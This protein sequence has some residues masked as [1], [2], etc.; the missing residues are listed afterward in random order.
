MEFGSVA[1]VITDD[2]WRLTRYA[3]DG[4]TQLFDLTNDPDERRDRSADPECTARKVSMLEQLTELL[5]LPHRVPQYR[6]IV[7]LDGFRV[8]PN[9][10]NGGQRGHSYPA[11]DLAATPRFQ[12]LGSP[13]ARKEEPK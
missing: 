7:E 10:N 9:P 5:L 6:A 11:Y 13:K 12:D 1:S 4:V 8:A 3:V 2:N